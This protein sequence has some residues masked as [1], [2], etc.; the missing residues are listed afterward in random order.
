[1]MEGINCM[2]NKLIPD[3]VPTFAVVNIAISLVAKLK[4]GPHNVL[5]V[6]FDLFADLMYLLTYSW[7]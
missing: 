7:S 4:S 1:M 6:G 3:T 2:D 5:R